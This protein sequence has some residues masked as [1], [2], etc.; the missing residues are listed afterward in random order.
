M[1]WSALRRLP[2]WRDR[3]EPQSSAKGGL[4]RS[5]AILTPANSTA[6]APDEGVGADAIGNLPTH[7]GEGPRL[8]SA[9]EHGGQVGVHHRASCLGQEEEE[10]QEAVSRPIEVCVGVCGTPSNPSFRASCDRSSAAPLCRSGD[11]S[12]RILVE[13]HSFRARVTGRDVLATQEQGIQSRLLG[14][15]PWP[16]LPS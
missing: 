10:L 2:S 14:L 12:G 4:K 6:R 7:G 9:G 16:F 5:T 1:L 3:P 8:A 11:Q 13:D 15:V